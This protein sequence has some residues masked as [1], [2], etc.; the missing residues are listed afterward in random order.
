MQRLLINS[1]RSCSLSTHSLLYCWIIITMS[2]LQNQC[3]LT[4]CR[5]R[6]AILSTFPRRNANPRWIQA[7]L[8]LSANT[9]VALWNPAVTTTRRHLFATPSLWLWSID[10]ISGVANCFGSQSSALLVAA[11]KWVPTSKRRYKTFVG[12]LRVITNNVVVERS[13]TWKCSCSGIWL[14]L[15]RRYFGRC[16]EMCRRS[17]ISFQD[18]QALSYSTSAKRR[19]RVSSRTVDNLHSTLFHSLLCLCDSAMILHYSLIYWPYIP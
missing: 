4:F 14:V 9:D 6:R 8:C 12:V 2:F 17:V 7:S 11:E 10:C 18:R 16:V 15:R 1:A 19:T 13:P 3:R 5:A